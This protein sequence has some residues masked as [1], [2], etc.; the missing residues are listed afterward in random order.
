MNAAERR[1]RQS[2]RYAFA[3]RTPHMHMCIAQ[4]LFCHKVVTSAPTVSAEPPQSTETENQRH[5]VENMAL[6]RLTVCPKPLCAIQFKP[7]EVRRFANSGVRPA[8][9]GRRF[10]SRIDAQTL[11][12]KLRKVDPQRNH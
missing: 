2:Q 10:L 6:E 12:K 7:R 1:H 8:C 5:S 9:C 11:T 3:S 4:I